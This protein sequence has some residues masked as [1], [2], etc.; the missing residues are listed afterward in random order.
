MSSGRRIAIIGTIN[1]EIICGPI[2]EIP[3]WGTQA[4]ASRT[5]I[6]YAGSSA[7]VAFPLRSLGHEVSVFGIVGS[8]AFGEACLSEL[9]AWGIDASGVE[10]I[11][12]GRTASCIAMVRNDGERLY[13]SDT[14]IL[15][16]YDCGFLDRQLDRLSEFDFALITGLFEI[17]GLTTHAARSFF[18]ELRERGVTTLL[19]TGWHLDGW[20]NAALEEFYPLLRETDYILPNLDEIVKMTGVAGDTET[21]LRALRRKGANGIYLKLGSRG[22]AC[23]AGDEIHGVEAVPV[24]AIN[25]TAAGEC[26]N[27]GVLHGLAAGMTPPEV[28]EFANRLSA[29]YVATGEYS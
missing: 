5:D 19:D 26:F 3:D 12:G 2:S 17:A 21:L 28:L 8:D 6:F 1:P 22:A 27:A 23:L 16:E 13:V 9:R 11:E 20:T 15:K 14:D 4:V 25:T 10:Q 7:R 18:S 24:T 29:H